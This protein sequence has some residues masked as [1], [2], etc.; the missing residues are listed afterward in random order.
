MRASSPKQ[1]LQTPP[2][3]IVLAV[4]K[5]RDAVLEV[6][7]SARRRL[8]IS[9]FRC[10][11]FAVL[12]AIAEALHRK[13]EVRLLLTPRA[14]G[15]E[16]RLK[17]LGAYLESMGAQVRRYAD[18][19]VKYHAKY[20]VADDGPALV[21]S[22]NFT[23]KCFGVTCDF[24]LITHDA[25]L[26]SGL[27]NLFETDWLAPHSTFPAGISERLVVGPDRARA[28]LT[29][30]LASARRSIH[31]IDHKLAD[32]AIGALLKAKKAEGVKV[33][34]L[35]AGQLGGLL[36]HGKLILIDGHTASFGS[37]ALDALSLDFRREVAVIVKDPRCVRKLKDFHRF[38]ASGGQ[39]LDIAR[40]AAKPS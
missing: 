29:A 24:I 4:E 34:V 22:L 32:P 3:R 21:G 19:V 16:K 27:Q 33:E 8:L 30:L 20:I 14:R 7:H 1:Q 5:R 12:D 39:V 26:V 36:P 18:A 35:G 23:G 37:M 6:I 17:E 10:T 15:W 11:D 9:L 38:L 40:I 31:I 25:G 28:Q 13:I 2:D